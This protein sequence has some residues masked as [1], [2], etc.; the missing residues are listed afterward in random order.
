MMST[1]QF[2]MMF[3]VVFIIK[4]KRLVVIHG[5]PLSCFFIL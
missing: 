2:I 4:K 5:R 3:Y 1:V